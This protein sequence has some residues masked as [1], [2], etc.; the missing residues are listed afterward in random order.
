MRFTLRQIE[1]FVAA[2]ETG[3]ITLASDRVHISQPSISAAVSHLETEFGIQLFIRHHAQGLSLTP[4]GTRFLR[5]AKTLLLQAHELQGVASELSSKVTGPVRIGCLVTLYPLLVP[6]V[7]HAFRTRHDRASIHAVAG[8]QSTLF[9]HLRRGEIAAALSYDMNLPGDM[10]VERLVDLPP[11]AFVA[12]GHRLAKR[13][14]VPLA[15]LAAEPFLLLDLPLSRDYFLSLFHQAGLT[16]EIGGAFEHM[17]VIRSLVARGDG[18]GLANIRPKNRA[19]L[20]GRPLA[21]LALDGQPRA[22]ALGIVF[23]KGMLRTRSTE[24]FVELCREL[25]RE[26]RIP[27]TG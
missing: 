6:E 16:P 15:A 4:Q 7:V 8:D 23:V 17:D 22:L 2:A 3:S 18:F 27:G 20:D 21:Y 19:S 1:Y 5:E 10:E 12:A 26:G 11:F 9:E 24:A 13:R 14:S 25:V